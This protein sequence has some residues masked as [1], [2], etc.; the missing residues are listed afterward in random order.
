MTRMERRI[1]S[2]RATGLAARLREA[3]AGLV[4]AIEPIDN[5]HWQLVSEPGIW[6]IGKDAEHVA[7]AA[8]YHEWIVRLTIGEK[9]SSRR[10]GLERKQMTSDLSRAEVV[11]LIR[12]RAEEGARLLSDL[13]DDQLDL[14]TRPPRAN[15]QLLAETI[16]RVLIG[17]HDTHR[18]AIETKLRALRQDPR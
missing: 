12:Q 2:D 4:A 3:A 13:T 5:R 10:P 14:P 15:A 16:D 11:D 9:V 8:V 18:A 7:E 6:S 17:H 1:G